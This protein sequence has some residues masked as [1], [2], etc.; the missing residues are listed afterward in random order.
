MVRP[1]R[2]HL[3]FLYPLFSSHS[4]VFFDLFFFV[5]REKFLAGG[6]F[7]PR[8]FGKGAG[9]RFDPES[10]GKGLGFRFGVVGG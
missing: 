4:F 5:E 7:G 9:G 3:V 1:M 8:V 10:L 2:L 6:R